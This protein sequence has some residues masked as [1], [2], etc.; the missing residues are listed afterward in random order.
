M[1]LLRKVLLTRISSTTFLSLQG[2]F[3]FREVRRRRLLRKILVHDLVEAWMPRVLFVLYQRTNRISRTMA[4]NHPAG[5]IAIVA[6]LTLFLLMVLKDRHR[7]FRSPQV[8]ALF[9]RVVAS[10]DGAGPIGTL[11][12]L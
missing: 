12:P 3:V 5:S 1:W 10:R 9:V 7:G 2:L 6:G 4:D 8:C 11:T